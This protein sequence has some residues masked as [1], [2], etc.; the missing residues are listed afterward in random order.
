MPDSTPAGVAAGL[1][2]F[3]WLPPG[4]I[5]E[6]VVREAHAQGLHIEG[7]ARH[8]SDRHNAPPALLIGYGAQHEEVLDRTIASLSCIVQQS[9]GHS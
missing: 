8:W 3:L 9:V 1:H 2:L 7:A 5:E 4:T 6:K